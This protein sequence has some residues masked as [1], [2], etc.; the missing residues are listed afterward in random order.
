MKTRSTDSTKGTPT[1]GAAAE[2]RYVRKR[3]SSLAGPENQLLYRS[4]FEDPD[5][6]KF[7]RSIAKHGCDP[8]VITADNYIVSGHRRH[9]AL[10]RIGQEFVRCRVLP[11]RRGRADEGPV[12]RAAPRLQPPAPQDHRRTGP[13]GA[14]RCQPRGGPPPPAC[15][16]D[17]SLFAPERNRVRTLEIEGAKKTL[18]ISDDKAEHVQYILQIVEGRRQYWPLSVR[19]VHY[20]LLNHDFIRGYYWPRR[21][22]ARA[23]HPARATLPQRRPFLPGHVRPH[24]PPAA[25]RPDTLGGVRRRHA[26]LEGVP[27]LRERPGVRP[28]G[29][30]KPVR[31]LLAG[32]AQTQPSHVEVVCEKN[33]IYHMV[34]RV[35]EQVPDPDQQRPR[36]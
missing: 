30:R 8:L 20:P 11:L 36:L 9:A 14:G 1:P 31:R 5:I 17:K 2:D 27:R 16:R 24:H 35:T 3:V 32:P 29:S 18:G 15:V 12:R 34:L 19:G 7:A 23:R 28:A 4:V 22:R 21:R 6:D 25:Q 10:V 26:P 33:T 13:R